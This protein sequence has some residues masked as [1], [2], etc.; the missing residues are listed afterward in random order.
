MATAEP[1]AVPGAA[2]RRWRLVAVT[3]LLGGTLA[4][5]GFRR[6]SPVFSA[7][8]SVDEQ[9]VA[10]GRALQGFSLSA[11]KPKPRPIFLMHGLGSNAAV[12]NQMATWIP[13][14]VPGT[15][16]YS[17]PLFENDASWTSL[18]KQVPEVQDYIRN[19]VSKDKES[20]KNGYDL[21]CHSQGAVICRALLMDMDD[22]EVHTFISM[23]G[24]QMGAW[25]DELKLSS[26]VNKMLLEADLGTLV[27]APMLQR[28]NSVANLWNDPMRQKEFVE[29]NEFL[30][31]YLGLTDD[32]KENARRKANFIR[33]RKAVFLVGDFGAKHFDG[34]IEPWQSAIWGYYKDGSKT[35]IISM[36][37]TKEYKDDLFGLKTL[38]EQGRLILQ[39]PPNVAH[40][41]WV[42]DYNTV[43]M[44][45][46]PQLGGQ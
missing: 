45:V 42:L 31:K 5:V 29:S 12:Y 44:Y 9:P 7:L 13:T 23:A 1:L 6:S 17:I 21:V 43:A 25:G 35:E 3:L 11:F 22:H 4:L 33:L 27:Y 8:H 18:L 46:L 20:F 19:I 24:P 41:A 26:G 14:Q 39:S 40:S 30:P 32:K 10:T 34:S 37:E 28:S 16:T 15:K 2:T 36:H 38:N